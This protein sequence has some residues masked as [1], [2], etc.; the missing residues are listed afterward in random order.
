MWIL[1]TEATVQLQLQV[2]VVLGL[3]LVCALSCVQE[4]NKALQECK[5]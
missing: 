5:G 2:A 4:G 1:L 3:G